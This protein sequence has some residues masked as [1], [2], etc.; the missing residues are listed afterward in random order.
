[1]GQRDQQVKPQIKRKS[2]FAIAQN[3]S[4]P[5]DLLSWIARL[6]RGRQLLR[7]NLSWQTAT[8]LNTLPKSEMFGTIATSREFRTTSSR[9]TIL[10]D[11]VLIGVAIQ[12]VPS[13]T[14][15]TC[16][17]GQKHDPASEND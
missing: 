2:C 9:Y 6:Y 13:T 16:A 3:L 5:T 7:C 17:G 4:L 10:I 8:Q 15:C 11:T 1:M 14:G 12:Y